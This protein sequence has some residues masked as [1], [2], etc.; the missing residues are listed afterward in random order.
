MRNPRRPHRILVVRLG[1]MGDVLHALPAVSSLKA[2]FPGSEITWII[3]PKWAVLLAGNPAVDRILHFN[4]RSL[5]SVRETWRELRCREYDAAIDFQGLIKSA[6][7]PWIASKC[8]TRFGFERSLLREKPAAWFY[9]RH[10]AARGPH[11]VDMNLELVA[12][13]NGSV[14]DLASPLPPGKP[15]GELPEG[16]FV[17]TSPLAGWISKQW[18]LESF[19]ELARLI[20]PV[21][22][23]VNGAPFAEAELRKVTG[24]HVHLSGIEGLI[25]ATRRARAVVGVDSGP[26]HLAAALGKAGVAIFG[27]TDPARNGPYGGTIEV[28]RDPAA[29]ITYKRGAT[30]SP[31]MQAISPAAVARALQSQKVF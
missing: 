30:I 4:R 9:N 1:A 13:A 14:R 5:A 27:P 21:P 8:R 10:C 18:P 29:A 20:A 16:P 3:D 23:V 24:A 28:L 25:D 15:E 19:T 12:A 22:L 6:V 26:L 2:S 11:V 7:L 17:L 31:S